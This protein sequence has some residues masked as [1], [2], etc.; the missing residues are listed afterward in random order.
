MPITTLASRLAE[1]LIRQLLPGIE[2]L[3]EKRIISSRGNFDSC[4][5]LQTN[6]MW[7]VDAQTGT[8]AP[9]LVPITPF[10]SFKVYP[11]HFRIAD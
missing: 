6:G 5:L 11:D 2:H 4:I 3:S 8:H 7:M 10:S 1:E 9:G